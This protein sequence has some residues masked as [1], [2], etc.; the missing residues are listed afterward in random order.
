MMNLGTF[1]SKVKAASLATAIAITATFGMN[2]PTTVSASTVESSISNEALQY[3]E[4]D[5]DGFLDRVNDGAGQ[6]GAKTAKEVFESYYESADISGEDWKF[7]VTVGDYYLDFMS[8]EITTGGYA[9]GAVIDVFKDNKSLFTVSRE[10]SVINFGFGNC[11]DLDGIQCCATTPF[12]L[13][14]SVSW[15]VETVCSADMAM[16]CALYECIMAEVEAE[17]EAEADE[18]EQINEYASIDGFFEYVTNGNIDGDFVNYRNEACNGVA[19]G[20]KQ[21]SDAKSMFANCNGSACWGSGI[22]RIQVYGQDLTSVGLA[23]G[24]VTATDLASGGLLRFSFSEEGEILVDE[25]IGGC[26]ASSYRSRK[27]ESPS[28]YG[29][30]DLDLSEKKIDTELIALAAVV[31]HYCASASRG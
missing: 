8:G 12:I 7:G 26:Y 16:A 9:T 3:A 27:I 4:A 19:N 2:M 18:L 22:W 13:T 17:A 31:D 15:G 10:G 23:P 24:Y 6:S 1:I 28:R 11:L 14:G 20:W 25:K 30:I 21:L 29:V 5:F